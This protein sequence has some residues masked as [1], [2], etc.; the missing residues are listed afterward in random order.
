MNSTGTTTTTV[1]LRYI[2][3][4][5]NTKYLVL[6][7]TAYSE[8]TNSEQY[9]DVTH[10][11]TPTWHTEAS[12][13]Q[14]GLCAAIGEIRVVRSSTWSYRTGVSDEFAYTCL[15][16]LLLLCCNNPDTRQSASQCCRVVRVIDDHPH[17]SEIIYGRYEALLRDPT[18]RRNG[19]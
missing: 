3:S 19:M 15:L 5:Y 10:A 18:I 11:S 2:N 13:L 7:G 14:D 16:F 9:N 6:P 17:L 8:F 12:V 4:Q 1:V